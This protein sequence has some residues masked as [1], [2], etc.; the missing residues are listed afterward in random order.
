MMQLL[1]GLVPGAEFAQRNQ[2]ADSATLRGAVSVKSI[3]TTA[4]GMDFFQ[5]SR[6]LTRARLFET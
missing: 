5:S 2:V 1:H 6:L 3:T 4:L